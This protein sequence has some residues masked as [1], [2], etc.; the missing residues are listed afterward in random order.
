MR[1]PALQQRMRRDIFVPARGQF[2]NIGDIL[3]RRQLLDWLRASGP[4][5]VYVGDAPDG[6]AE[7]LGLGPDDVQYRSFRRWYLAALASAARGR[8]S[9]VFKPGEIQL[10]LVG[11]KEHLAMLPVL[12]LV[13]ARHGRVARVGVGSRNF[14]PLPRALMGPSIALSNVSLWRDA[15]TAGYL[16]QGRVMPDLAFAGAGAN[17]ARDVPV[18]RRD[19]L[20]VSMRSDLDYPNSAWLAGVRTVADDNGLEIWCVTQVLRDDEK[21]GQLAADLG[22]QALRWNGTGHDEQEQRLRALYRRAAIA[23]SDRLHVLVGAL[24]EGAVPAALLV[25]GKSDKIARHFAAAGLHDVSIISAGLS[26]AEI[27]GRL[28]NLLG[29]RTAILAGLA[30]AQNELQTVRRLLDQVLTIESVR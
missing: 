10:T 3:L 15:A 30:E 29:R 12:A 4:L 9:Y 6:Y 27:A 20:V 25:D 18:E 22:G 8:A 23:V 11:M 19:V 13:R 14:A 7:G 2:D 28:Q 5:H 17:Q 21:C 26:A 16:G 24:T 1:Q